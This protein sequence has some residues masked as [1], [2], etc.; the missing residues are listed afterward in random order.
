LYEWNYVK[1]FFFIIFS[2]LGRIH[3]FKTN[4]GDAVKLS[5][6]NKMDNIGTK[7]HTASQLKKMP[8][9]IILRVGIFMNYYVDF[10]FCNEW[11]QSYCVRDGGVFHKYP[12]I[13]SMWNFAWKMRI[14]VR[15][16]WAH[17]KT[18][19]FSAQKNC[20]FCH[21]R[22][23]QLSQL[24]RSWQAVLCLSRTTLNIWC[25]YLGNIVLDVPCR[26][27]YSISVFSVSI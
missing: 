21:N 8:T 4:G 15:I 1:F 20:H 11:V 16:N 6:A 24:F 22:V 18:K 2:Y 26:F 12:F 27:G 3:L 19:L 17:R 25:K 13:T 9:A 10:S 5:W 7:K 14:L 23:S